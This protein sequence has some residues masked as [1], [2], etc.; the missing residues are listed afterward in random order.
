[1]S[2]T[3]HTSRISTSND[4]V[5]RLGVR[6]LILMPLVSLT[7]IWEVTRLG[8]LS[9][10]GVDILFVLVWCIWVIFVLL[11]GKI[12]R[13]VL[14]FIGLVS[15]FFLVS[16]IGLAFLP[17]YQVQWPNLFRFAQTILW[18]GLA[19]SFVKN[20]QDLNIIVGNI[21]VSGAVLS[22][23]SIYLYLATPGLHRIAG[24]FS[25]AG[26]EGF[27]GQASF[28]EIGA[29]YSLAALLSLCYLFW[30]NKDFQRWKIVTI[31]IGFILNLIGLVLVQSRSAF[32]AFVVGCFALILPELNKLFVYGRVSKKIVTFGITILIIGVLIVVSSIYFLEVNRMLR[33]FIVESSEYTSAITRLIL[34]DEAAKVWLS[35]ASY[36]L[37]GYGFGSADRFIDA[38][39]AHNFFLDI[40]L[41][42][43]VAGLL[44]VIILLIWPTVK[45]ASRTMDLLAARIVIVT[46]FVALTV[47]MFGST[48]IDP[49]YGGC[50]FLLLY[51][52]LGVLFT[53]PKV[54]GS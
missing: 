25:A 4:L 36:F 45:A 7:N 2:S 8:E 41:W 47:S 50:T 39:S 29:L 23:F 48:L 14:L 44:P 54:R 49:F 5:K 35:K 1:M 21:V 13:S 27:G 3:L 34:W 53:T 24:F 12:Y 43:G 18:G 9:I 22:L 40:G 33:T 37:I 11:Y 32:L 19:L 15:I 42:L 51:G 17:D 10:R 38:E 6:F 20:K 46:F 31:A 28:N 26:G 30:G 16:F 52:A